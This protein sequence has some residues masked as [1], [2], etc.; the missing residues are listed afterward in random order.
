V[1]EKLYTR[2]TAAPRLRSCPL[3]PWLDSFI[4]RLAERGYTGWSLRSNVVLAAGTRRSSEREPGGPGSPESS[5]ACAASG[6]H[7]T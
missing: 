1:L 2:P 4:G 5:Y 7:S 6:A 3:G